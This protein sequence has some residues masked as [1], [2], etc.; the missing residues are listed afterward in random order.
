MRWRSWLRHGPLRLAY[1]H[2]RPAN[3]RTLG[4]PYFYV[5][6]YKPAPLSAEDLRREAEFYP[7]NGRIYYSR[8][9]AYMELEDTL[10]TQWAPACLRCAE[11]CSMES[12]ERI[13][14]YRALIAVRMGQREKA[15][16]LLS[17]LHSEDLTDAEAVLSGLILKGSSTENGEPDSP[18]AASV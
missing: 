18:A 3:R 8:A 6:P 9:L 5:P 17:C 2:I 4:K 10:S 7:E 14:L 13:R 16:T 15:A 1:T 12:F 11:A